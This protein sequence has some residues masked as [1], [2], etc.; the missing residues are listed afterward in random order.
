MGPEKETFLGIPADVVTRSEA[1]RRILAML[2]ESHAHF[3]AS[4]NPEICVA[5][6]R[7]PELRRVLLSAHL[8]TPDGVGIVLSSRLRGGRI[9]ERVTGIDLMRD[10]I[11]AAAEE[12]HSVFLYGAARGVAAE[13]ANNLQKDFPGLIVAGT[14]HGF[15]SPPEEAEVARIIASSGA[16]LVFVGT[17]SPRQEMFAAKHGEATGARVLMVVGGSFDVLS[18]RL[19]RAPRICQTL[20][21]EWLY[22]LYQQ[23]HRLQR[24]LVLPRFLYL[25]LK[26]G[27]IR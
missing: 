12:G 3:V 8:S 23:P 27:R 19:R 13:A 5:A 11:Q 6:R 15:V 18:G 14:H 1:A 26:E 9:R 2:A 4:V 21:L 20:G 10:L 22:R 16:R 25:S 7:N 24:A 17:G